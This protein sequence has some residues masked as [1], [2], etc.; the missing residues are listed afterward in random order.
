MPG[1]PGWRT[2]R[3]RRKL[4]P[5]RDR[6]GRARGWRR[7]RRADGPPHDQ[8]GAASCRS[9]GADC[10]G[11]H[12]LGHAQPSSFGRGERR[13]RRSCRCRCAVGGCPGLACAGVGIHAGMFASLP[14][15]GGQFRG[16]QRLHLHSGGQV[17][18]HQRRR[19]SQLAGLGLL[20]VL[21]RGFFGERLDLR[22]CPERV[23]ELPSS[24]RGR[25]PRGASGS[26]APGRGPGATRL[27]PREFDVQASQGS[28]LYPSKVLVNETPGAAAPSPPPSPSPPAT[29]SPGP[30]GPAQLQMSCTSGSAASPGGPVRST[31]TLTLVNYSG[32][33][34]LSCYS[35]PP[36]ATRARSIAP[37]WT[38]PPATRRR[39]P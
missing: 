28:A 24:A 33:T 39:S 2:S 3:S 12:G 9:S 18:P 21:R 31:C 15:G 22:W 14:G 5:Y 10:C 7:G 1:S 26:P 34:T 37:A 8:G 32:P 11:R 36:P 17:R 25:C 19:L 20:P 30:T 16:D 27:S 29:P 4:A 35:G 6:P 38:S 13:P 23:R